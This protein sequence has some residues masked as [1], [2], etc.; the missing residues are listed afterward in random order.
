VARGPSPEFSLLDP[1]LKRSTLAELLAPFPLPAL[2]AHTALT[3]DPTVR[4]RLDDYLTKAR[5]ERPLI[6]ADYLLAL[7]V[8][9]GPQLGEILRR[10]RNAKLDGSVTSRED[11]E[12]LVSRLRKDVS[13][14]R[15]VSAHPEVSKE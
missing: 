14:R 3:T 7:G 4:E 10:L 12:H 11:E 8:P 6:T 9:R 2:W 5:S 1:A 15:L 13:A